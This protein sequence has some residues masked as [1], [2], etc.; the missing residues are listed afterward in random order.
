MR[1]WFLSEGL[2]W[3]HPFGRDMESNILW[4]RVSP[5]FIWLN[6]KV[7]PAWDLQ[8]SLRAGDVRGMLKRKHWHKWTICITTHLMPPCSVAP[9]SLLIGPARSMVANWHLRPWSGG[10][11]KRSRRLFSSKVGFEKQTLLELWNVS[12]FRFWKVE[13]GKLEKLEATANDSEECY[14]DQIHLM[15]LLVLLCLT[16]GSMLCVLTSA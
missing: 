4:R 6:L 11:S 12:N 7:S 8:R 3:N 10:T 13:N 16:I 5:N 1:L 14:S 2:G 15:M 9:C